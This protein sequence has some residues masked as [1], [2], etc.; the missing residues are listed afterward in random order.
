MSNYLKH[1]FDFDDH[2]KYYV[3]RAQISGTMRS[4]LSKIKMYK[5]LWSEH[6]KGQYN[7]IFTGQCYAASVRACLI[8]NHQLTRY[9]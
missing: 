4:Y 3:D 1:T 7:Y 6:I 8:L 9:Y 2:V 5:T